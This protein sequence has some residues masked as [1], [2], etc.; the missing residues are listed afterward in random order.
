MSGTEASIKKLTPADLRGF[1]DANYHPNNAALI[2]AGDTTEAALRGKLEAAFKG[3]HGKHVAARKLARAGGR[4]RRDQDLPHR[5]GGRA[6]VVDPGRPGRHR[7][8]RAP[9]TSRSR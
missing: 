8:R 7:A 9:T 6:A 1:Y 4:R 5:Q 2:V 3:W